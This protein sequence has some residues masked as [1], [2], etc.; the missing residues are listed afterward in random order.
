MEFAKHRIRF[1]GSTK[2]VYVCSACVFCVG[3][4]VFVIHKHNRAKVHIG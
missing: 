1:A 2:K 3:E 4:M